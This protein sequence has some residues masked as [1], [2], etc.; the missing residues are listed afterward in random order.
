MRSISLPASVAVLALFFVLAVLP[1]SAAEES[2]D[3][4]TIVV[5]SRG[6]QAVTLDE[7]DAQVMALP[8]HLRAGFLDNPKRIEE[9]VERLLLNKQ[10]AARAREQGAD[11]EPYFELQRRHAEEEVLARR[12]RSLNEDALQAAL[13]DFEVLAREI[14]L[15][16]PHR[17]RTP[18]RLT[19]EHI[20]IRTSQRG[21]EAARALAEEARQALLVPAAE[22]EPIFRKFSDEASASSAAGQ[23]LL[24]DVVPGMMERPFEEAVFA[25]TKVGEVAPVIET[26]YGLHVVRLRDRVEP[27]QI[28]YEEAAPDLIAQ[29]RNT[30]IEGE[31][32]R[33]LTSFV[34]IPMEAKQPVVAQ[35]RTRYAK[36]AEGILPPAVDGSEPPEEAAEDATETP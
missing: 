26:V 10:L 29:Q 30:Y 13:P 8:K 17:F 31:K 7:V 16:A 5:A 15:A 4:A 33:F 21:E 36:A 34:A 27:T 32:T 24:Q 2:P 22:F 35:L 23:G 12:A 28:S 18:P 9:L 11:Q 3:P 1:V 19:L 20:L 14:Y 6:G 25:L